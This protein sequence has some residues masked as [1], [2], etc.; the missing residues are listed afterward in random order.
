MNRCIPE[1]V[2]PSSARYRSGKRQRRRGAAVVEFAVVAPVFFLL[3][4]GLIE[5]GRMVMVQQVITNAAREGCRQAILDGATATEID[6]IVDDY[7]AAAN[8]TGGTVVI[9]P[10]NPSTAGAGDSITVTVNIGFGQVS[11]LPLPMFLSE[12]TLSASTVM[13][14]ETVD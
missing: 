9:D 2:D 10:T 13:R 11:W 5:F 6:T 12:T 8:I 7:L 3:V 14:R 1:N 4:F